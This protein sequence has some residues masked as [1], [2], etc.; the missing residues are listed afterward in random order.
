MGLCKGLEHFCIVTAEKES[1]LRSLQWKNNLNKIAS[2]KKKSI[3]II[4]EMSWKYEVWYLYLRR[5]GKQPENLYA[6]YPIFT[7]ILR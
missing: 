6:C 7:N 2:I 1:V 4:S 5:G 3:C